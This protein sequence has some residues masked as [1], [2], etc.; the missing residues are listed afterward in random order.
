[1][2]SLGTIEYSMSDFEQD[3]CSCNKCGKSQ[4]FIRTYVRVLQFNS[5]PMY[6]KSKNVTAI[7]RSCNTKIEHG[8]DANLTFKM[9]E[10]VDNL[11]VP[12]WFYLGGVLYPGAILAVV[13]FINFIK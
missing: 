10:A 5:L 7:C 8:S 13:L 6:P 3:L 4:V 12:K 2:I 11:K 9:D 1:M